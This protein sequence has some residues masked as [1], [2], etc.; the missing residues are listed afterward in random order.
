MVRASIPGAWRVASPEEIVAARQ[1]GADRALRR[2]LGDAADGPEV[3]EAAELARRVALRAA[4]TPEG[5][6]LFAADREHV[7][8]QLVARGL[9]ARAVALGLVAVQAACAC[10]GWMLAVGWTRATPWV[11][12]AGVAT[13]ALGAWR[14]RPR[15]PLA[16]A[17]AEASRS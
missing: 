5:R 10:V 3:A 6:P 8:H 2:M 13:L 14:L 9:E 7:H 1:R 4:E 16:A 17:P 12:A 15:G 11:M